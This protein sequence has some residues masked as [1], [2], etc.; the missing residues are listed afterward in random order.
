MGRM[1]GKDRVKNKQKIV[2]KWFLTVISMLVMYVG[3]KN[4][5]LAINH[6]QN[7]MK[8][9]KFID[10]YEGRKI[11]FSPFE[12][13]REGEYFIVLPSGYYANGF[14]V[15]LVYSDKLYSLII[16]GQIYKNGDVWREALKEAKHQIKIVDI[17]GNIH[18]EKNLQILVSEG[19]PSVLVTIEAKEE[20]YS[21]KEYANKQYVEKGD[22]LVL[23]EN[24]EIVLE[25][26][27]ERFKVR[28]NL[29]SELAKKPFT[30]TLSMS[31][32]LCGMYSSKYWNLLANATDY[33]HIRNKLMLDWANE[34]S[35]RYTPSGEYVDLFVNGEYQGLYLLTETMEISEDR[36]NC[37]IDNSVM[38]EMELD[39]RA[40]TE[41]NYVYTEREH[42]WVVHEELPL[43][44]EK[45][46]AIASYLNEI[47]SALYSENGRGKITGRSL[48]QLLDFDSWTDTWLLKEISSDHD[49]GVTSQFA[50]VENWQEK[51]ILIAG[52][53]WDFDGTLGNGMIPWSRN[54]RN[55]VTAIWNT[56]GIKSVN[57]NKWLSKMYE[58]EAFRTLL[59][60]KYQEKI[61]PKIEKLLEVEID[62]YVRSIQR[63]AIL[64]SLRWI[65]NGE[66]YNF[67]SSYELNL[68]E[69]ENYF[70]KYDVL[71]QHVDIVKDFL[72]EKN[73]FLSQLWIEN[74][75]FEVY[76]EEHN[77]DGMNLELNNNIY[78]WIPKENN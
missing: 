30:F 49:L 20:L 16:D 77:E 44:E 71:D 46:K 32:S 33:S 57:Q 47:E 62:E 54:P 70:V 68:E 6:E 27:M 52:P 14:E 3:I 61:Q 39:Y 58:N 55:L 25:D 40:E 63:A 73:S 19:L 56:K 65:G 50:L 18:M 64:D 15:Q 48:E 11:V 8:S 4:S 76:I 38:L 60:K 42:Y 41:R 66:Y 29:T 23:N 36:V 59:I 24:G 43:L 53:E 45:S 5:I 9:L 31:E 17:F 37:D 74:M 26:T 51:S 78:T 72:K 7:V 2:I 35:E 13:E 21:E 69:S 12:V 10:T 22:I 75:E 67:D 28:G 34:L 1:G